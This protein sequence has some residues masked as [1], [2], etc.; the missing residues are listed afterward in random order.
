ML[1]SS[2]KKRLDFLI[3][4]SIVF[5]L[6]VLLSINNQ[7]GFST[8]KSLKAPQQI[9]PSRGSGG[10]GYADDCSCTYCRGWWP[11]SSG[12]DYARYVYYYRNTQPGQHINYE[13]VSGDIRAC[14]WLPNLNECRSSDE[15]TLFPFG[16]CRC[17]EIAKQCRFR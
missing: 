5:I 8:T 16:H 15:Q 3:V 1:K 13:Y 12:V 11:P 4:I 6:L 17:W 2:L 14:D 10:S 7:K 9:I